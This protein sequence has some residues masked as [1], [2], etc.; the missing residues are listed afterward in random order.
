MNIKNKYE[1]D[2]YPKTTHPDFKSLVEGKK[3]TKAQDVWTYLKDILTY[4]F[5]SKME[6]IFSDIGNTISENKKLE[7]QLLM[8]LDLTKIVRL[9]HLDRIKKGI[10]IE[11]Q[12]LALYDDFGT[13]IYL[14][15]WA[16][17]NEKTKEISGHIVI[18]IDENK[19][20]SEISLGNYLLAN[21][22]V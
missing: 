13:D 4:N 3:I 5:Q 12:F 11:Y 21:P 6:V 18:G 15:L 8:K 16:N 20:C 10:Y 7:R 2:F 9:Y 17:L 22:L 1:I 19:F 14:E